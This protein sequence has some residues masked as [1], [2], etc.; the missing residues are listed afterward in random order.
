M[1]EDE[2]IAEIV[3]SHHEVMETWRPLGQRMRAACDNNFWTAGFPSTWSFMTAERGPEHPEPYPVR[4]QVNLLR[5]Q[6]QRVVGATYLRAPRVIVTAPTVRKPGAKGNVSADDVQ[7]I[8]A[9]LEKFLSRT[10]VVEQVEALIETAWLYPG[11]A[12]KLGYD[13]TIKGSP[14][15]RLWLQPLNRWEALW[16]EMSS[17]ADEMTYKG[18][19]RWVP[20]RKAEQ[21]LDTALDDAILRPINDYLANGPEVQGE[22]ERQRD[23]RYVQILDWYD[24]EEGTFSQLLVEPGRTPTLKRFAKPMPVAYKWPTGRPLAPIEPVILANSPGYRYQPIC[25]A[26]PTYEQAAQKSLILTAVVNA[27][28]RDAAR[29]ILYLKEKGLAEPDIRRILNAVDCEF[30][31]LEPE[32]AAALA[33][34]FHGLEMPKISDTL[35]EAWVWLGDAGQQ[36]SAMSAASTGGSSGMQY[37]PATAWQSLASSDAATVTAQANRINAVL[38][39]LC[40][41]VL[42]VLGAH[43]AGVEVLIGKEWRRVKPELLRLRW[44]VRVE[45]AMAAQG[46]NQSR[47]SEFVQVAP[48]Y[49]TAVATAASV[50]PN[51]PAHVKVAN[52]RL[53]DHIVD[54]YELPDT[55]R[56]DALHSSKPDVVTPDADEMMPPEPAAPTATATAAPPEAAPTQ[57]APDQVAQLLAGA[58]PEALQAALASIE[59]GTA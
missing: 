7:A 41:A 13:R 37:A 22:S 9:V 44:E 29:V 26:I 35:K 15:D 16:D 1:T 42:A 50:D 51:A 3:A 43:S 24:L 32:S 2:R 53:V 27:F 34:L 10:G 5:A 56:W 8:T 17:C 11:A 38:G 18:Y 39:R 57:L 46:L 14:I 31:G 19:L 49:V 40:E 23:R 36:Q 21:L 59:G 55:F 45:D 58:P 52:E 4:V 28:R 20:R 6:L 47:R 54:M 33:T 25:A 48:V 12:L 30:V